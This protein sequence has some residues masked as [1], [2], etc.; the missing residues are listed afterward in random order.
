MNG[1]EKEYRRAQW[2]TKQKTTKTRKYVVFSH[3][4]DVVFHL[5]ASIKIKIVQ[6]K[7]VKTSA[8]GNVS[9]VQILMVYVTML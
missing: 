5:F 7:R 8:L 9:W 4:C 3:F 2:Q 1:R 6:H